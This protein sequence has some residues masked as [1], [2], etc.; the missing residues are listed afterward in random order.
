MQRWEYL[1]YNVDN[2][3]VMETLAKAGNDGWE[4]FTLEA[5]V[6]PRGDL[7]TRIYVKRPQSQYNDMPKSYF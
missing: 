3:R 4:A 6:G 7:M 1:F 5:C 2:S